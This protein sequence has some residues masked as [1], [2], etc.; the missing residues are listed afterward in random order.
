MF[1][2]ITNY[3]S[4]NVKKHSLTYLNI[5]LH[6]FFTSK[7]TGTKL[8]HYWLFAKPN[9]SLSLSLCSNYKAKKQLSGVAHGMSYYMQITCF[10]ELKQIYAILYVLGSHLNT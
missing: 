4:L 10:C 5:Y 7:A 9:L 1:I 6:L 3:C 2:F 8:Q